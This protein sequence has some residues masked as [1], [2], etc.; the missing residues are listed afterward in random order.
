MYNNNMA[1]VQNEGF[2]FLFVCVCVCVWG[3]NTNH[4]SYASNIWYEGSS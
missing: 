2:F 1:A 4:W 3:G